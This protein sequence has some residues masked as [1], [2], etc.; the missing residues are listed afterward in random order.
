MKSKQNIF[1]ASASV[2]SLAAMAVAYKYAMNTVGSE[3]SGVYH[4][5]MGAVMLS[6][7]FLGSRHQLKGGAADKILSGVMGILFA[8]AVAAQTNVISPGYLAH[9]TLYY[10][11]GLDIADV[12][13]FALIAPCMYW[14]FSAG[15]HAVAAIRKW[16]SGECRC[17]AAEVVLKPLYFSRLKS[18]LF[19]VIG[20]CWMVFFITYYPGTG[21]G[22]TLWIL[23]NPIYA[24]VQHIFTYN[25][26][27]SKIFEFGSMLGGGSNITGAALFAFVQIVF[28]AYITAHVITWMAKRRFPAIIWIGIA[29]YFALS[30]NMANIACVAIKDTP[31]SFA[32]LLL[33]PV[34]F[35]MYT[36]KGESLRKP[37]QI[38][39]LVIA[40]FLIILLRN[41]GLYVMVGLFAT[42]LIFFIRKWKRIICICLVAVL[43]PFFFDKYAMENIV[44]VKKK[45]SEM[46]GVPLQ[47]I[48]MTVVTHGDIT[49]EQYEFID[50]IMPLDKIEEF[51]HPAST[52]FIKWGQ[53]GSYMDK[54]YLESNMGKFLKMWFEMLIPNFNSY[55]KAYILLTHGYWGVGVDSSMQSFFFEYPQNHGTGIEV[56]QQQLLPDALQEKLKKHYEDISTPSSGTIFWMLIFLL[57]CCVCM[58]RSGKMIIF[59]PVA[60]VWLTLM[61]S[62]PINIC[63]R[64][65]YP[66]YMGLPFIAALTIIPHRDNAE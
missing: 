59:A 61:L 3:H 15:F 29:L 22:D 30:A 34:L 53:G 33:I 25:M 35:D 4:A 55:V 63:L 66:L 11:H 9:H 20:G 52:D 42:M 6:A 13:L 38:I 37:G 32:T 18:I 1:L 8:L 21:F 62:V 5:V 19:F 48:A 7:A 64:Y 24:S 60:I 17:R 46:L 47:Q 49:D 23:S 40:S 39:Q 12:I 2:I 26:L 50:K 58:K 54:E 10:F 14:V 43:V 51:Y 45:T 36:T 65:C 41:N 31:F 16:A 44:K 57:A 28:C 56:P 27:Y